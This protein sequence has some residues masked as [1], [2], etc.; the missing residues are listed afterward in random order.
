MGG[1]IIVKRLY[2]YEIVLGTMD[3]LWELV[4]EDGVQRYTPDLINDIWLGLFLNEEYLGMYCF[5]S[6][7]SI[8]YEGHVFM[9]K[10]QETILRRWCL[11]SY[12]MA[13]I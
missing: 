12:G 10:G 6:L 4:A 1:E 11:C 2:D 3:L 5:K 9:L 8:M 13:K 7:T